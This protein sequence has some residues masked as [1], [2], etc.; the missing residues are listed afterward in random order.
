MDKI[1]H[2]FYLSIRYLLKLAARF[3]L[4][5]KGF[6][7]FNRQNLPGKRT[8][9]ILIA[10][11]A[12]FLDSVYL[13]ASLQ[14]RFVICGAKPEYF[15]KWPTRQLFQMANILKVESHSQF[16]RD[17]STLLQSGEMILIYPEMGRNPDGIGSFQTWA[18]EVALA[19]YAQVIPC[20]LYGTTKGQTGK[21]Q[22]FVGSPLEPQG[23]LESLTQTF[24]KAIL[25]LKPEQ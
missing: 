23:T 11:H 25:D 14:P 7:V 22:L 15:R 6:R 10:N 1:N 24:R 17:C 9:C 21:K 16:L 13:I 20:Y 3:I 5:I 2:P 19:E 12:A 4:W 8:A 18:A